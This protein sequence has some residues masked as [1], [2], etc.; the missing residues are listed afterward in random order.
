MAASESQCV[1]DPCEAQLNQ[2]F[3]TFAVSCYHLIRSLHKLCDPHN[4]CSGLPLA[5]EPRLGAAQQGSWHLSVSDFGVLAVGSAQIRVLGSRIAQDDEL[6]F[7]V[8]PG[9]FGGGMRCRGEDS[10]RSPS[11]WG[12]Q[13]KAWAE[14]LVWGPTAAQV[15]TALPFLDQG[16]PRTQRGGSPRETQ[17]SEKGKHH[18]T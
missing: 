3:F 11:G 12:H 18:C 17:T 14:H 10:V 6:C 1:S 15:G 4:P 16:A 8:F 2:K 5:P 13:L 9:M 7:P